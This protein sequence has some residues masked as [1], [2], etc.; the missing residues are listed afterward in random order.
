MSLAQN[1]NHTGLKPV[2]V[3]ANWNAKKEHW[4]K[5]GYVEVPINNLDLSGN[6][7][8]PSGSKLIVAN[9]YTEKERGRLTMSEG[10]AFIPN[11]PIDEFVNQDLERRIKE[12]FEMPDFAIDNVEE[13]YSHGGNTKHWE[14]TTNQISTID[15]PTKVGDDLKLGFV[16]RNG[17]NTGTALGV[18]LFT[19]RLVCSNGAIAKGVDLA[20]QTVRHINKNPLELLKTFETGLMTVIAEWKELIALYNKFAG[21]RLNKKMAQ[22]IWDTTRQADINQRFFA[23]YY[24]LPEEEK[25]VKE[26]KI[27]LAVGAGGET[28]TLWDDYNNFTDGLYHSQNP[29]SYPS[30]DGKRILT[31]KPLSYESIAWREKQLHQSMKYIVD[32]PEQFQE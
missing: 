7:A 4:L 5:Y 15:N 11:E 23:K 27:Q 31:R 25:P 28:I 21:T 19:F 10:Q 32:N 17:Y 16:I 12:T 9:A 3:M 29:S 26:H 24:N 14:V 13:H 8:G 2:N 30:K 1:G 22:Y 18:D 20:S 6:D